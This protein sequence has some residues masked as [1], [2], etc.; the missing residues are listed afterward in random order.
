MGEAVIPLSSLV[1][2]PDPLDVG[3]TAFWLFM[4][5]LS[6]LSLSPLFDTDPVLSFP[7]PTA[8]RNRLYNPLKP[9]CISSPASPLVSVFEEEGGGDANSLN[10]V[11]VSE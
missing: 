7:A 2:P 9:F 10:V 4:D 11:R 3:V 1:G 5:T 6:K 8:P